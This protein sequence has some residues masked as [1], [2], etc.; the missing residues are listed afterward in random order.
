MSGCNTSEP[1]EVTKMNSPALTIG[2]SHGINIHTEQPPEEKPGFLDRPI[3]AFGAF[4]VWAG[5]D[6]LTAAGTFNII[7][8]QPDNAIALGL[9]ALGTAILTGMT[10]IGWDEFKQSLHRDGHEQA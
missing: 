8:H 9:G 2:R 10:L 7:E 3:G 4:V 6:A 5:A 1:S